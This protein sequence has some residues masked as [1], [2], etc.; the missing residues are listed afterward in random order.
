MIHVAVLYKPYLD[1]IRSG[2][3]SVE[4]RLT[5]QARA[6]YNGIEPGDRIYFKQSAGPF[7]LTAVADQVLFEENL[8]PERI[9]AIQRDYNHLICGEAD[10]WSSRRNARF[11]TLIWL[12]EL[13]EVDRG[14]MIRPLQGAAW[15]TLGKG[16]DGGEPR[17]NHEGDD[18]AL[19]ITIT[20]GNIRNNTLYATEVM[21][22]IPAACLGGRTKQDAAEPLTLI[23]DGGPMVR[24]DIVAKRKLFRTRCWGE[25]FRAN[26]AMPGDRVVLTPMGARTFMASIEH[27][28]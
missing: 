24:T 20:A 3:K 28:S 21:E 7:A 6:P 26:D 22:A 1:L 14:P 4:C 16:T 10:Y 25:W 19:R 9:G 12:R 13:A 23:L 5:R 18:E 27:E 17:I 8:T 15:A 2:R 11:L